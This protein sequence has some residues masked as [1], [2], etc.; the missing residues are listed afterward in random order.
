[1][2]N[3]QISDSVDYYDGTY[4]FLAGTVVYLGGAIFGVIRAVA[5]YKPE[6]NTAYN[7]LD[8]FNLAL[9]LV[10]TDTMGVQLSYKIYF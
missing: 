8:N 9:V 4:I 2:T 5:Y 10:N 3:F 7:N 6:I 1:V